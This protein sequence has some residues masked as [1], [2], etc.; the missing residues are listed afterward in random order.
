MKTIHLMWM[1]DTNALIHLNKAKN[2]QFKENLTR[3]ENEICVSK[4]TILEY[5]K[6]LKSNRVF[7][8]IDLNPIITNKALEI[9]VQLRAI[10]GLVPILDLLIMAS[11]EIKKIPNIV[12]NDKH[13]TQML[14]FMKN[15]RRVVTLEDFIQN[16]LS[17]QENS[18]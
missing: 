16:N 10:G 1:F 18:G 4:I 3:F 7:H 5:P 9:T 14:P 11:A 17:P 13:F 2:H 6:S 8:I 15:V 12:S